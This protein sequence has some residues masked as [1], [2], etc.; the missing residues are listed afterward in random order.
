MP[1]RD[2]RISRRT[3]LRGAAAMALAPS[4]IP[5]SALGLDGRVPPS[6][7]IV[8]AGIGIGGRG[9]HDLNWMLPEPDVQF[10]AICDSKKT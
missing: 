10:V 9:T 2:I 6:E 1:Q 5:A 3:F 7:R 4:V 8:M